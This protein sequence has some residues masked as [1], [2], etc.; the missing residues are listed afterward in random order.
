MVSYYEGTGVNGI[1][2]LGTIGEF[3]M[4]S[5]QERKKAAD[6]IVGAAD[7]L[8]VIINAGCASTRETVRMARYLKDL[9]VDAVIAVEPYF[10]HPAP[11]GMARHYLAIAEQADMPVMAYNIPQYAGNIL[12]PDIMDAFASDDRIVGLKDSGGSVVCLMEFIARAPP[13][14]S[15]MV[16][17]DPLASYALCTGAKGMM[18]GSAA[19]A[20]E[21]CV[22]MYRAVAE[23]D[24][25]KAFMRQ[26]TLNAVIKAMSVG[27]FP[28]AAK[29]MLSRR[30]LAAGH[31]RAPLED[32][33]AEQ[34]AEVDRY[35]RESRIMG[36]VVA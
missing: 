26:E 36:E 23:K 35:L 29:H 27:T 4:M 22:E 20:P 3:A 31:V 14:F 32:L 10:Y 11:G 15:V 28:A 12:A 17:F 13:D 25:A 18:I 19:V 7:R 9:G 34:K 16:G 5:E 33:S 1:L 30:G 24:L 8:E 6:I 21:V 2:A